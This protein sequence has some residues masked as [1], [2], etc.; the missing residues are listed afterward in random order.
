MR[1][2]YLDHNATTPIHP[3]VREAMLPFLGEHF[4]NPSSSHWAGQAVAAPLKEARE[5]CAALVNA[6]P[7]EIVFTSGGSEGDNMAIKGIAMRHGKRGHIV[8]STI[9]HS[10]VGKTCR[11]LEDFGF[12]VTYVPADRFG[13]VS[14]RA[15]AAALRDDTVLVSIMLANN[16]TGTIN[17]VAEIASLC[18]ARGITVH[19][20]AVQAVGKIP[21]DV[22]ALGVDMLTASGHKYNAPKGVGFQYVRGGVEILPLISGGSQ[23][24]GLRAGTE[25][26]AGIVALG[27]ASAIA[28]RE[29]EERRRMIGALR[30]RLERGLIEGIPH[31]VLNGHPTERVYNT[32]NL[33][34]KYIEGEAL[35][36]L[37][38]LEGIA[39]STGSACHSETSEPSHV[40]T[41][42]GLDPLCSRGA[43]RFSFGF[44]L[45]EGD[46]DHC[47]AIIPPLARRLQE[48][49]PLLPR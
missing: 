45:S 43:L 15:V 41:A 7:P 18:R 23:E 28:M 21:L 42:M 12:A 47:L 35:M 25:N 9:E 22:R 36:A 37:L 34:I 31:T 4:G 33:S 20:D 8:T 2:I 30:E 40:L 16:E 32:A 5:R 11:L 29:M 49:S 39:I 14:A 26:V 1:R 44:G 27:T 3:E 13:M 10:A 19:T 6:A 38:G 46:I 24:R 17:P 48:M